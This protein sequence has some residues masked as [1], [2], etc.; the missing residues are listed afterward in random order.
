MPGEQRVVKTCLVVLHALSSARFNLAL[1][2][3]NFHCVNSVRKS[4]CERRK[5]VVRNK[6]SLYLKRV[7][8][9]CLEY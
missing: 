3:V 8:D 5:L 6:L 1:V 2:S 9:I 7:G 4:F